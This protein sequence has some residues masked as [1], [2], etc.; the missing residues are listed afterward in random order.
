MTTFLAAS[1][2]V[3]ILLSVG[4]LLERTNRR[5]ASLPRLPLGADAGR[6]ADFWRVMHDLDV[7]RLASPRR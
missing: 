4:A 3:I 6:D 2:L 5:A 7:T 1:F